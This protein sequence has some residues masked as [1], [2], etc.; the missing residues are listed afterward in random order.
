[1]KLSMTIKINL[2]L[3]RQ[4]FYIVHLLIFLLYQN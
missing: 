3:K 2:I 1:M 4:Q